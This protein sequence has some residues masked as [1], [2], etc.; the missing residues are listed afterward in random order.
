M[1]HRHNFLIGIIFVGLLIL[2]CRLE[3]RLPTP[4]AS[5]GGETASNTL[6]K[7]SFVETS[8]PTYTA[9]P[10]TETPIPT[11]T[12]PLPL[13]F[14]VI[15]DYGS[16]N[17]DEK[18]VA[19]LVKSWKVEFI[20]TTGDNNYPIGSAETIDAHIGQFYQE[21]ISPYRGIYGKGAP[22][23][24][25]FPSLG[26]HDW[27]SEGAKP[28]LDYFTLP[29]NERYY[30]FTWGAVQVFVLDSDSNEPDGVGRSSK[31]AKWL[32]ERLSESTTAWQI[33]VMHHPPYTSGLRG[34]VEWM[35]WPFKEWGVDAVLC[36]HD[37]YY[38]R[39]IVDGLVYIINGAGGG[40]LYDFGIPVEGSK[41]RFNG[42]YG[43]LLV[44]VDEADLFFQFFTPSG[45]LVDE[46]HL[47]R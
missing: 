27:M 2:S 44:T 10:V 36:G 29:G 20:V 5:T 22:E 28:Y 41:K 25:F 45:N 33:V 6:E 9:I 35:R 38:E 42:D 18:R 7:T 12:A 14:A 47:Q 1:T 39:L 17:D 40:G 15:G 11:A 13:R 43:A 30:D 26:N 32:Q 19:D 21:F 24:R 16:G 46:Y 37:H 23:N 4:T 3:T 34:A 8:S 31:Q